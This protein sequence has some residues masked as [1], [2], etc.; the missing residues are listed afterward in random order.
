MTRAVT[1]EC[2]SENAPE[3]QNDDLMRR[4]RAAVG[5]VNS[6]GGEQSKLAAFLALFHP[7]MPDE[8]RRKLLIADR[9]RND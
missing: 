8:E 7:D 5:Y 9:C 1:D 6:R 2:R 3:T 4:T